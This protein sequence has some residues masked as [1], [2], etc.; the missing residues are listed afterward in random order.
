ML[1]KS[2]KESSLIWPISRVFGTSGSTLV[3]E[4]DGSTRVYVD[5]IYVS[6]WNNKIYN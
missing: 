2:A 6:S 3:Y 5:K 1:K 4:K